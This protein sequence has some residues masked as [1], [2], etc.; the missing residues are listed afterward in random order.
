MYSPVWASSARLKAPA[1]PVL[2]SL[3]TTLTRSGSRAAY[4]RRISLVPSVEPSSLR[5]SSTF[6]WSWASTLSTVS[7]MYGAWLKIGTMTLTLGV[8]MGAAV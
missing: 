6:G 3:A 1:M 2:R 5:T 4:S 8:V 7:R